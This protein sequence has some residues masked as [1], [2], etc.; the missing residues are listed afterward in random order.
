VELYRQGM[1]NLQVATL[2]EADYWHFL[3][4]HQQYPVQIVTDQ[5]QQQDVGYLCTL[6]QADR[7]RAKV[8][9]SSLAS[10]EMALAVLQQIKAEVHDEVHLGWPE[11]STLV[12]VGR[13]LGSTPSPADQWLIRLPDVAAFLT[14]IGPVLERRLAQS[15]YTG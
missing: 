1:A 15:A 4:A 12:Q 3:L 2:R 13:G 14:R 8:I 10:P 11:S 9:E 6:P 5:A 7:Q